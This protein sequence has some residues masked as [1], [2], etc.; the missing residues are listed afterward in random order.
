MGSNWTKVSKSEEAKAFAEM[1]ITYTSR[2]LTV[3]EAKARAKAYQK[4][5]SGNSKIQA[6]STAKAKEL[7]KA[8]SVDMD[9]AGYNPGD[10]LQKALGATGIVASARSFPN[11][12]QIL[13]PS[14]GVLSGFGLG[15]G[16]V[17]EGLGLNAGS[18]KKAVTAITGGALPDIGSVKG[19]LGVGTTPG[20]VTG[21]VSDLNK[22]AKNILG[23]K[24]VSGIF[25]K[26][27]DAVKDSSNPDSA[28]FI[29]LAP[30]IFTSGTSVEAETTDIYGDMINSPQ[31]RIKS[32]L[33]DVI[34]NAN[35]T[36]LG[37]IKDTLLKAANQTSSLSGSLSLKTATDVLGK[38][39]S[40]LFNGVPI[41]KDGALEE[42]YKAVG[43]DAKNS[44]NLKSIGE[45]MVN[46]IKNNIDGQTGLIA[47]YKDTK[48]VLDGD[49]TTA[50]GMFKILDNF[51]QN[52]R[53]SQFIDMTE[54]FKI[55]SQVS[56]ALIEMGAIEELDKVI[57]KLKPEDKEKFIED[58]L[59][60]S[61][62]SGELEAMRFLLRHVSVS[63]ILSSYPTALKVFVANFEPM[64]D[65]EGVALAS[66]YKAF[67]QMLST[68]DSNWDNV[69]YRHKELVCNLDIFSAFNEQA[70]IAIMN[71]GTRK[72]IASLMTAQNFAG[73]LDTLTLLQERYPNYPII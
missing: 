73:G 31:N 65:Q 13:A 33:S 6:T 1:E 57:E 69:G 11:I 2:Q 29:K 35:G 60:A 67:V 59:E 28:G 26:G 62:L 48:K 8:L 52:T 39:K 63:R 4:E 36:V 30:S 21:S 53:L 32:I 70:S 27:G 19:M 14:S 25:N 15:T 42:I 56:K 68:F 10:A 18:A 47:L 3:E 50:E 17:P 58:N 51:T 44:L 22:A 24:G 46:Q 41:T 72:Q 20:I 45:D 55:I 16:I 49:Y 54:Q 7:K 40:D 34:S 43:Y 5:V 23:G 71:S 66:E 12:K 9:N 38:F 37:T 64:K 61:L